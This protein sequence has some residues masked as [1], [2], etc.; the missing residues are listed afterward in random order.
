MLN[1]REGGED[2]DAEYW[3]KYIESF[4][5][6]SP[7]LVVLNK[8]KE[9]LFTLN[10]RGLQQKHPAVRD[11][12]ET[13][14]ADRTGLDKL[15]AAVVQ[16][17]G[18]LAHL[19]DAFPS[20]WFAIKDRLAGMKRNYLSF[21]EYRKLCA[22]HGEQDGAAQELLAAYLHYLGIALNYK[23]D[24]RL[25]DTHVLNP[26]WVTN[27]IYTILNA[28]RLARQKGVL[29]LRD[30]SA[31]LDVKRY[32]P[33]MHSFL[34]DLMKKFELCFSFPEDDE[35]YL[36]PQLLDKEEPELTKEFRPE[37]CLH[38]RYHYPILPEGL[39][40]RFIVRTNALSEGLPRWRT[41]V[42]LEFEGN[43]ALVKADVQDKI[44]F[45]AVAGPIS[46]RRRLLAV[47]RSD[48]DQIHASI[49]ELKPQAMVPVPGRPQLVVPYQKLMVLEQKG[50]RTFEEVIGDEV[51]DLDVAELL[52]GIDL[53]GSRRRSDEKVG[54]DT[55]LRLFFSYSHKDERFRNELGNHLKILERL[56]LIASWYDRLIRPGQD[57]ADVIDEN[58]EH[59]DL[60]LLLV[61]H[62][63]I[64]SDYCYAK[65]MERA[66]ERHD[67]GEAMVIPI[68][69]RDV[70]WKNAPF[71]HLQALPKD[72]RAVSLWPD[73]DTAWR[74][75]SDEI[76]REI[77]ARRKSR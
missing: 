57:W 61:K 35:R 11:F 8:I 23:D 45:I 17:T 30:V 75:V 4:G 1:G 40:P 47:I 22:K 14:C 58:L 46:G 77:R 48:F 55:P 72:G 36:V 52:D 43:R 26:H 3:L 44:V 16:E 39:L 12:I 7:V 2:A 41:G 66:L 13:D 32:P 42:V 56:G 24:P 34:F 71:S 50:R 67:K 49:R 6:D 25:Q 27:G 60:I 76:E 37:A 54:T 65:E 64:S 62:S 74:N 63:F 51:L 59:H 29:H 69:V 53:A 5:G 38:F 73:R 70:N 10:R 20:S 15:R 33:R 19:R 68:I 28:E 21:D 9:H 31:I 18:H